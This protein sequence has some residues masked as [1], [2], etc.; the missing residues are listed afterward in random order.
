M[1]LNSKFIIFN[2]VHILVNSVMRFVI[3]M[4]IAH[5]FLNIDKVALLFHSSVCHNNLFMSTSCEVRLF[6][7]SRNRMSNINITYKFRHNVIS[8]TNRQQIT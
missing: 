7:I 4:D 3:F 6:L 1:K 2:N 5:T 8:N